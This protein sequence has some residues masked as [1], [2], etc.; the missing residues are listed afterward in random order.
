MGQ[1]RLVCS[2]WQGLRTPVGF[3]SKEEEAGHELPEVFGTTGR[4]IGPQSTQRLQG[5]QGHT[6]DSGRPQSCNGSFEASTLP[7]TQDAL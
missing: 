7:R 2:L 5:K 3:P 6:L 1:T 4:R